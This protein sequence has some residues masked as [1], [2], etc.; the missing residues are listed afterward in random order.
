MQII[1]QK[2]RLSGYINIRQNR[3]QLKLL[4][5]QRYF[6]MIKQSERLHYKQTE[7]QSPQI[8]ESNSECNLRRSSWL[9]VTAW[10]L[11][12]TFSTMDRIPS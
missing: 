5:K 8:H 2:K 3:L 10:D 6:M 12:T 11:N 7:Q 1:T 9:K 4:L